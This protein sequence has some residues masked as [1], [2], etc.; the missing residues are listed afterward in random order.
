MLP[1]SAAPAGGPTARCGPASSVA[2]CIAP[3]L[4]VVH[5]EPVLGIQNAPGQP[6]GEVGLQVAQAA[7]P[8]RAYLDARDGL[9]RCKLIQLPAFFRSGRDHQAA[10]GPSSVS[11]PSSSPT[12]R[13][14]RA[15]SCANSSSGPGSLSD[16]RMLPSPAPVVPAAT[17]P[18]SMTATL[19]P[20]LA[21]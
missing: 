7:R 21:R 2:R 5:A 6:V 15:D 13:H 8:D 18:R 14:S 19:S 1:G 10:L 4:G 12:C 9:G 17:A 20:A 3:A 16:T 11:G